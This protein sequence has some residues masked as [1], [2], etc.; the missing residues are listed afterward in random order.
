MSVLSA[1]QKV[2]RRL[3]LSPQKSTLARCIETG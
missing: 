3:R 1:P 2:K